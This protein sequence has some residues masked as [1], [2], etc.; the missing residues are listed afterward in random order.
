MPDQQFNWVNFLGAV[1]FTFF[2]V[3]GCL[4]IVGETTIRRSA[5]LTLIS[6]AVAGLGAIF[7]GRRSGL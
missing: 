1:V 7:F 4:S 5:E 3:H 6:A 2:A